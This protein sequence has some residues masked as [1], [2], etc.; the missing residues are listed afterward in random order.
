M[1]KLLC[2]LLLATPVF[3]ADV[4][5]ASEKKAAIATIEKASPEMTALSDKVWA[6]AETALR[7]TQSSK[8][9]ADWAEAKG[10]RVTR[11]VAGMP[12][13]FVAEFGS[14]KPVRGR[15]GGT[16]LRTQSL[17]RRQ[18]GRRARGEGSDRRR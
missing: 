9:L 11:G 1:R 15:R 16:W 14:G 17:R 6:Y 8:A 2:V 10:F 18:S 5:F 4:K 13:A 3:A 12:T 7:E